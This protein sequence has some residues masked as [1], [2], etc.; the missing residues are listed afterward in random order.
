MLS[1]VCLGLFAGIGT[2]TVAHGKPPIFIPGPV[3]PDLRKSCE[4][5][6]DPRIGLPDEGRFRNM[7]VDPP[8]PPREYLAVVDLPKPAPGDPPI[9]GCTVDNTTDLRTVLEMI[10]A[11]QDP[12]TQQGANP[13]TDWPPLPPDTCDEVPYDSIVRVLLEP[14]T[15]ECPDAQPWNN[16]N[17]EKNSFR[18]FLKVPGGVYLVNARSASGPAVLKFGVQIRGPEAGL[19]GLTID[20]DEVHCAA[21]PTEHI[22]RSD[23][24]GY[25]L[26]A[27]ENPIPAL[28]GDRRHA[29]ISIQ[30]DRGFL[31]VP[32]EQL[33]PNQSIEWD[34]CADQYESN[35]VIRDTRVNGGGVVSYGIYAKA[36]SGLRVLRSEISN[37]RDHG[38]YTDTKLN[39]GIARHF[40][41]A[42]GGFI[43]PV[44]E[45][46][47][48]Q[49]V[50]NPDVLDLPCSLLGDDTRNEACGDLRPEMADG[51]V[52][53]AYFPGDREHALT[54][55][56]T[57]VVRRVKIRDIGWGGIV[58]SSHR[59]KSVPTYYGTSETRTLGFPTTLVNSNRSTLEHISV[60]RLGPYA[61]PEGAE[62]P[63]FEGNFFATNVAIAFEKKSED[64]TLSNFCVGPDTNRGVHHEYHQSPGNHHLRAENISTRNGI[65]DSA[66][67][68]NLFWNASCSWNEIDGECVSSAWEAGIPYP[69]DLTDLSTNSSNTPRWD[70]YGS[71]GVITSVHTEGT[72]VRDVLVRF[73]TAAKFL[74]NSDNLNN[75]RLCDLCGLDIWNADNS[76]P[77]STDDFADG[78]CSPLEALSNWT[79]YCVENYDF[80]S[81]WFEVE[82][83]NSQGACNYSSYLGS[84]FWYDVD[85]GQTPKTLIE[86]K[87]F[88]CGAQPWTE[89]LESSTCVPPPLFP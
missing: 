82:G 42:R 46:L 45:D 15:Y 8:E 35:V 88:I 4:W 28:S 72:T 7:R 43:P 58:L 6:A 69:A 41:V 63:D 67:P 68:V 17:G 64:A 27:N 34:D 54:L 51:G 22:Y 11:G 29:G 55:G 86:T 24:N 78:Y 5:M 20:I 37:F 39:P 21:E 31:N 9:G 62:D 19:H 81:P 56:T 44:F 47:T 23:G 16:E 48:V 74:F 70:Q 12:F 1:G 38:I 36:M 18:R 76:T 89:D 52:L 40:E 87:P 13:S 57:S 3:K 10:A 85:V 83:P 66:R 30:T 50:A 60:D 53:D 77:L 73:A 65:I 2:G 75:I 49:H 32:C 79:P 26:D 14:G 84:A 61:D 71:F 59:P 33:E 80:F 25:A